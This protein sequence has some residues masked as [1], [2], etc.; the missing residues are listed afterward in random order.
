MTIIA[1]ILIG[2]ALSMD[3]L[4][5]SIAT[6]ASIRKDKLSEAFRMAGAFGIFQAL[7]PIIG[8]VLGIKFKDL[9]SDWDHWLAFGILSAIGIKMIY[10]AY[11]IEEEEKKTGDKLPFKTL[12]LLAIATSIDALATGFSISLIGGDI[13]FAAGLIGVITFLICFIGV[14]VG[15]KVGHILEGKIEIAGG[16]ILILVGLKILLGHIM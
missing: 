15:E 1:I 10:E 8:A 6:G 2:L 14:Y 11:F 12:L 5:V 4:A 13:L 3:A 9:M 7:M 16:V